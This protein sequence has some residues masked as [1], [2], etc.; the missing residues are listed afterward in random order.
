RDLR[1]IVGAAAGAAVCRAGASGTQG[2]RTRRPVGAAQGRGGAEV[3]DRRG[4]S[5]PGTQ[6]RESA[7]AP[8]APVLR[9]EGWG[10]RGC[11]RSKPLT[12]DPSPPAYWGRGEPDGASRLGT[13]GARGAR[14]PDCC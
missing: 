4:S 9:G 8:L 10:V 14:A 13:Q 12:P 5:R 1:G 2:H 3:I 11:L 6:G 7:P